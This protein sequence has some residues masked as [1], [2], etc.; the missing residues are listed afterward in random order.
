M[1]HGPG[2]GSRCFRPCLPVVC[3]DGFKMRFKGKETRKTLR[4]QGC[5][6]DC[7][8][9]FCELLHARWC[10]SYITGWVSVAKFLCAFCVYR[11]GN[12]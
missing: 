8:V 6:F 12:G 1:I 2:H 9:N 4:K 7:G 3:M 11:I 5:I 10:V